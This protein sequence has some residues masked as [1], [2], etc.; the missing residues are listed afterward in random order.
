L[1]QNL[2]ALEQDSLVLDPHTR[3]K[4]L[5]LDKEPIVFS[6]TGLQHSRD[7]DLATPQAIP[8]KMLDHFPHGHISNNTV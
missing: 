1:T 6:Q 5:N 7:L 3:P 4:K 2:K 8:Q